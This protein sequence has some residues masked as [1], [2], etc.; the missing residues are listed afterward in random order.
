MLTIE[1]MPE[2]FD[3]Y[4]RHVMENSWLNNN[5]LTTRGL[6]DWRSNNLYN[7]QDYK[8]YKEYLTITSQKNRF[9]LYC[10]ARLPKKFCKWLLRFKK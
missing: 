3:K 10:I 1:A 7:I 2:Y 5:F 6:L 9:T 4:K 8:L